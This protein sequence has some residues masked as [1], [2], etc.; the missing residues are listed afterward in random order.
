MPSRWLELGSGLVAGIV[1]LLIV[2]W[3]L[4]GPVYQT[5][6]AS[7]ASGLGDSS[8]T[9][10][11]TLAQVNHGIPLL[12]LLYFIA[13]SVVLLGV[14]ASTLLHWRLGG[15]GWRLF[16]WASVI[17]LFITGVAGLDLWVLSFPSLL[18]AV[19]A[20]VAASRNNGPVVAM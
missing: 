20:A 4:F 16:L 17:L 13:L 10:E 2:G 7:S 6:T 3:V 15:R 1:G 14:I 9:G 18:L 19:V 8:A 5:A 12:G 11:A